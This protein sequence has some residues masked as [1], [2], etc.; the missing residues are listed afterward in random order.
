M[1]NELIDNFLIEKLIEERVTKKDCRMQGVV[2]EGYPKNKEQFDNIKNMKLR[3][4]LIVGIDT[5]KQLSETRCKTNKD[6]FSVRYDN[7][8]NLAKHLRDSK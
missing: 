5:P 7:W 2:I 3:P 6:K 4:T 8:C 1:N